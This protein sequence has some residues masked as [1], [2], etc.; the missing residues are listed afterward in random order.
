MARVTRREALQRIGMGTLA[1]GSL[2]WGTSEASDSPRCA[3]ARNGEPAALTRAA[4]EALGGMERFVSPGMKVVIKP[5]IGW[6]KLPEQ[7]ANTHPDVIATLVTLALSAGAKQVQVMDHTCNDSRRCY[8]RSG[9]ETAAKEAGA[10]VVH[11]RE[12]R[13]VETQIGGRILKTWPVFREFLEAD[14]LINAPIAKHHGLSKAT[15]GM[16]NWYGAVGGKRGQLHQDIPRT[17]VD[18]AAFFKPHLT[19]LDAT[20]VLLRNGPQGGDLADVSLPRALMAG[21]DPV[22]IDA[23]GGSLLGLT[24]SDLP[25]LGFAEERGL[26]TR[27]W[28]ASD[29][30]VIDLG[31]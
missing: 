4:L 25:H 31:G 16:K 9:I 24:P 27:A 8:K 10:K 30:P 11:L 5:N 14:V 2:R 26:G 20:R 15:L 21:I 3:L 1:L 12:N 28:Q 23:F 6:D 29:V 13:A 7:G 19:V 17:C 18:M 22:A